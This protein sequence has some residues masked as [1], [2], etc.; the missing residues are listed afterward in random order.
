MRCGGPRRRHRSARS[1][2]GLGM[3]LPSGARLAAPFGA[4]KR[5]TLLRRQQPDVTELHRVAVV[6]QHDR[7]GLARVGLHAGPGELHR[8]LVA[9]LV[10]ADQPDVI[11]YL[12]AILKNG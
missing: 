12:H 2:P 8:L 9:L 6:L 7:P 11:L 10:L 3:S 1:V 5:P 4:A